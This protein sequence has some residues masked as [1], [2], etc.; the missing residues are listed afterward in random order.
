MA[1]GIMTNSLNDLSDQG[2]EFSPSTDATPITGRPIQFSHVRACTNCVRAKAKC[3]FGDDTRVKCERCHRMNKTCQPSPPMRKRRIMRKSSEKE[4]SKLEQ[5]LDGLVTLLTSATQSVP[6]IVNASATN[7]LSEIS[8]PSNDDINFSYTPVGSSGN[9]QGIN[10]RRV[11]SVERVSEPQ[12]TSAASSSSASTLGNLQQP[13]LP[14]VLQPSPEDAEFYLNKFRTQFIKYL[15]FMVLAPSV[16][17]HQLR[18]DRPIL[19]AAIMATASSNS[20]QQIALSKAVRATIGREAF[21]EGT[22]N[23]DLLLGILVYVVW[24]QRHS[25]DKPIYLSLGQ[26]AIAMLYELGLDKP[27]T[28]DPAL[29]LLYDLKGLRKPSR[30]SRAPTSEERRALLGCFL[31]SS[32]SSSHLRKGDALR[33]TAYSNECLRVIETQKEADSDVLL[34]QL[35]KLRLILEKVTDAPWS[36]AVTQGDQSARPPAMFYLKSLES[37][38]RDFKSKIPSELADNKILLM[39]LY[40]TELRIHE[41]GLSQSPDIFNDQD[42]RRLECLYAC[43]NAAKGWVDVFLSIPLAQYV[44]FS[45]PTYVNLIHWFVSVYRLS[46]F[47]HPEWDRGF[48]R[49][50]LDLS[51]VL[52][53]TERNFLQVKEVAGL[54]QNGSEDL[55]TFSIMA[56]KTRVI[57]MWW[58]ATTMSTLNSLSEAPSDRMD[59]IPMDFLDDN[60]LR[61]VLG[62]WNE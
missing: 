13:T 42:N 19:W 56:S 57:K 6:T 47:E 62:P 48:V 33:W 24:D 55:D 17:S 12:F 35:V 9:Q 4:T 15:P 18:Q 40:D 60:W 22:R 41:I 30:L 32:L 54:D 5:K 11:P 27:A 21:V 59:D 53:T 51:L 14:P 29:I 52:E 16:T 2:S 28:S 10:D 37:Q 44:G 39:E 49:E 36:G 20:T 58:E 43:L 45:T 46:T 61:D 25:L 50:N 34:V 38:I 1:Q 23:M 26:L 3:S 7:T 8:G 31:M